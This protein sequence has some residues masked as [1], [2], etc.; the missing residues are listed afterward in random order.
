MITKL[1]SDIARR[2][3]TKRHMIF[4]II[5]R[6][7]NGFTLFPFNTIDY[8]IK[9]IFR[10]YAKKPQRFNQL[11]NRGTFANSASD[12]NRFSL[13]EM[14]FSLASQKWMMSD[15]MGRRNAYF[16]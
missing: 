4:H 12:S 7:R 14:S 15:I 16:I 5:G 8:T 9:M 3:I 11:A 6:N 1:I 2:Q 10:C 13:A